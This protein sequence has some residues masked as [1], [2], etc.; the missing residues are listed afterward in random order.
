VTLVQVWRDCREP[1]NN[2]STIWN[3]EVITKKYEIS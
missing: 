3:S 2:P 1:R